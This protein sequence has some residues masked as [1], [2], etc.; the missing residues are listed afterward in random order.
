MRGPCITWVESTSPSFKALSIL[1]SQAGMHRASSWTV[2]GSGWP[3]ERFET[4]VAEV[5]L[6][7]SCLDPSSRWTFA[8]NIID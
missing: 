5:F 7:G 2:A 4:N 1:W 8:G 3:E 6:F